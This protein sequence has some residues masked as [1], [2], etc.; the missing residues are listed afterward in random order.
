MRSKY[1]KRSIQYINFQPFDFFIMWYI[2]L[3]SKHYIAFETA[4]LCNIIYD[5]ILQNL[6]IQ[7]YFYFMNVLCI[8]L[9]IGINIIKLP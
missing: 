5:T 7:Y 9:F 1:M 4:K 2:H 3:F 8:S 6:H